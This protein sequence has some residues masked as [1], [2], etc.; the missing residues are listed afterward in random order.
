VARYKVKAREQ[1]SDR[2]IFESTVKASNSYYFVP[3]KHSGALVIGLQT[4]GENDEAGP[5]SETSLAN[6]LTLMP[7]ARLADYRVIKNGD[8]TRVQWLWSYPR[9]AVLKGF[10]LYRNGTLVADETELGADARSWLTPAL[11]QQAAM[12]KF[13]LEAVAFGG[14]ISARGPAQ[15]YE[16]LP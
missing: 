1:G 3:A 5:L 14:A 9:L 15:Y 4:V 10:R 11:G 12:I 7:K 6:P 8:T 16:H 2:I 13:E